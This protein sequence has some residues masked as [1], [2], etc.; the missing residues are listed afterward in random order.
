VLAPVHDINVIHLG[1]DVFHGFQVHPLPGDF[2][3]SL[4]FLENRLEAVG[5]ADSPVDPFRRV[6]V[7]FLAPA[8][9]WM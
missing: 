5:L 7:R 1:Q 8:I 4:V 3:S 2:L 6:P 9:M